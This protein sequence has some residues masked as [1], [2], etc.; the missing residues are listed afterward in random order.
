MAQWLKTDIFYHAKIASAVNSGQTPATLVLLR[1]QFRMQS[2]ICGL[3][4]GLFYNQQL[5]TAPA[6]A[7]RRRSSPFPNEQGLLF[8]DTSAWNPWAA[9]RLGTFSRYNVFHALLIRNIVKKLCD[10]GHLLTPSESSEQLGSS[11]AVF[12]AMPFDKSIN[13]RGAVKCQRVAICCH[14]SPLSRE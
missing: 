10:D 13:R 3:V 5:T 6:I 9:F 2:D 1:E 7:S 12:G 14:R 4:N 8:V 11:S